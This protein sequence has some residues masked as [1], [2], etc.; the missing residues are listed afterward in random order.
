MNTTNLSCIY[1]RLNF[2]A[3]LSKDLHRALI[4][5]FDQPLWLKATEIIHSSNV[6]IVLLL[7]GFHTMSFVGSIEALTGGSGLE[8]AFEC[9]YGKV[10]FSHLLLGEAIAKALLFGRIVSDG[11]VAETVFF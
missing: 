5:M 9:I 8:T 11:I 3:D 10:T 4:V 6:S 1:S 7:G 2:I